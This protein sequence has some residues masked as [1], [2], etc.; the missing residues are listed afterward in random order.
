[1]SHILIIDDAKMIRQFSGRLLKD[2]GFKVIMPMA[3][4]GSSF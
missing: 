2:E 4:K 1:M 3:T